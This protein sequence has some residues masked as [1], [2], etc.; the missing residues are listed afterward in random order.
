M[1]CKGK[2][3]HI[4][5]SPDNF[6]DSPEILKKYLFFAKVAAADD[7]DVDDFQDWALEPFLSVLHNTKPAWGESHILT[8]HDYLNP[9]T[10]Y[11][12]LSA[13]DDVLVPLLDYNATP[14][15]RLGV[16]LEDCDVRAACP[17]FHPRQIQICVDRPEEIYFETP[18]K[19]LLVNNGQGQTVVCFL[20]PWRAGAKT[21]ALRELDSYTRIGKL[22]LLG[23]M[24]VQIPRLCGVVRNGDDEDGRC[25]GLL[26]S[27]VDCGYVTLECALRRPDTPLDLLRKW[28]E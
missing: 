11:Y 12:L 18:K 20:K 16:D 9:D 19:V 27:W 5:L 3:F 1:R 17:S 28:A 4:S 24:A 14:P 21:S 25:I 22:L 13:V 26:L 15:R 6:Q 10:F 2:C 7:G 8:L 23:N